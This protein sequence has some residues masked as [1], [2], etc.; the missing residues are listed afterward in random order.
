MTTALEIFQGRFGRV[1]LLDINQGLVDHAHPHC[2]V[3]IKLGGADSAFRVR[4]RFCPLTDETMVLVNAWEQ[5]AYTPQRRSAGTLILALYIE[6]SWL[7]ELDR[8]FGASGQPGFFPQPVARVTRHIR[9][10]SYELAEA[11]AGGVSAGD[12]MDLLHTLMVQVIEQFSQW[13]DRTI[14]PCIHGDFRI[15]KALRHLRDCIGE[16]FIL[17][18]VARKAGLSRSQLFRGFKS[19]LGITPKLYFNCLRMEL[20]ISCLAEEDERLA[21]LADRLGF[22]MQCHFTRFFRGHLGITPSRYRRVVRVAEPMRSFPARGT[23]RS[24]SGRVAAQRAS[25]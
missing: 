15:R 7:A 12:R 10:A 11:L 24:P 20:A 6:P 14:R 13:R 19:D 22:S 9:T 4:D 17:E 5:H 8:L 1:A 21:I 18:D 16:P 25:A 23:M 2:H 3:L